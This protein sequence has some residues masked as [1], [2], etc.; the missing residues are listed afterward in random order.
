LP[1]STHTCQRECNSASR[2]S[3]LEQ[4]VLRLYCIWARVF[5]I[6]HLVLGAHS[7]EAWEGLVSPSVLP[8]NNAGRI[9]G[10]SRQRS[11][12]ITCLGSLQERWQMQ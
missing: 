5:P 2:Q 10:A 8:G 9:A 7:E 4:L 12:S 6:T 11:T 1:C 3:N